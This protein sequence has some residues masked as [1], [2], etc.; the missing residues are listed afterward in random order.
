[1]IDINEEMYDR[2]KKL[3]L[4]QIDE[5]TVIGCGGTGCWT[6]ILLG[7]SGVK[8]INIMD[9]D[10]LELTNL[11]RLPFTIEDIGLSKGEATKAFI[12]KRRPDAIVNCYPNFDELT[13]ELVSG[14]ILFDCTDMYNT[15]LKLSKWCQEKKI[16]YIRAGYDGIHGTVTGSVPEWSV[17]ID[18]NR[19]YTHVPSWVAPAVFVAALAV[20]KAMLNPD[21]E[22][23]MNIDECGGSN[24]R[25]KKGKKK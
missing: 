21:I 14:S 13:S 7:M 20:A 11:N 23:S 15:Q 9:D 16:K 4:H 19:G 25:D 22:V 1:M 12:E 6:A 3:D 5:V 10:V 17:A 8:K 18:D 24:E 2:Q